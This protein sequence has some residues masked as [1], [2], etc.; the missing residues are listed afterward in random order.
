MKL[1][2]AYL[3]KKP[4]RKNEDKVHAESWQRRQLDWIGEQLGVQSQEDWYYITGED[5]KQVGGGSNLLCE[6]YNNSYFTCLKKVYPEFEWNASQFV[7]IPHYISHPKPRNYWTDKQHRRAFMDS[8]AEQL[9]IKTLED[10]YGVQTRQVAECGGDQLLKN[11]FNN[12]LFATLKS[13][14]DEFE[15]NPLLFKSAPLYYWNILDN[16]TVRDTVNHIL[17]DLGPKHLQDISMIR[18]DSF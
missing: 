14:Y 18:F 17:Q 10:W 5:V 9:G 7:G 3:R 6:H 4:R 8:V 16:Q 11:Y 12:S 15:W 13:V 2:K 1:I